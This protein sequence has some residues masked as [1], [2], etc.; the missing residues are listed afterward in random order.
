VCDNSI[1]WL[2]FTQQKQ[3]KTE[4]LLLLSADALLHPHR[5][6]ITAVSQGCFENKNIILYLK[7]C[8]SFQ[9]KNHLKPV[10]V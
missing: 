10:G 8:H 7:K 3:G 2:S 4:V 1:L 9:D 6:H 5:V